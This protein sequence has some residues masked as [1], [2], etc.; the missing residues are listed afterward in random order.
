MDG[1]SEPVSIAVELSYGVRMKM[2]EKGYLLLRKIFFWIFFFVFILMTPIIVLYSVGYKFDAKTK[3]F[4][5]SGAL[6]IRAF[7]KD[8]VVYVNEKR[9]SDFTPYIARGVVPGT[10]NVI[11]DKEGFYPYEIDVKVTSAEVADVDVTLMPK[12]RNIEKLKIDLDVYKFFEI[13][14][15]FL[16][17]MVAFTDKGIYFLGSDFSNYRKIGDTSTLTKEE[18]STIEGVLTIRNQLIFWNKK[19]IWIIK[20]IYSGQPSEEGILPSVVYSAVSSVKNIFLGIKEEY[21]IIHDGVK[22]LALNIK[23]TGVVFPIIQMKSIAAEIL[24]DKDNETLYIKDQTPELVD[25]F[26]LFKI[27]L[28]GLIHDRSAK[29]EN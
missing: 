26:S 23:N 10:Y 17:R 4:K 22:L 11:L 28:M 14:H 8:A 2:N 29:N 19:T 13:E 15:F 7:P 25:K 5:M 9:V 12:F 16:K 27:D 1:V 24:Y 20:K 3:K 21:L 6:T 18:L